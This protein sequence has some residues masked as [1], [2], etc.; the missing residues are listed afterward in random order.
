CAW[1]FR[2]LPPHTDFSGVNL[3]PLVKTGSFKIEV[4]LGHAIADVVTQY[5][6]ALEVQKSNAS[7]LARLNG[8]GALPS[9]I[10]IQQKLE[11]KATADESAVKRLEAHIA[12][13]RDQRDTFLAAIGKLQAVDQQTAGDLGATGAGI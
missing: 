3:T 9:A 11:R 1:G 4:G 2:Q 5:I 8:W 13:A 12:I 7:G 10:A 6:E